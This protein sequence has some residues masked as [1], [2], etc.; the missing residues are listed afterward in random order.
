MSLFCRAD[1][2]FLDLSLQFQLSGWLLNYYYMAH[3]SRSWEPSV[4]DPQHGHS[5]ELIA[6][7]TWK[8][9]KLI[10][11]RSRCTPRMLLFIP[12]LLIAILHHSGSILEVFYIAWHLKVSKRFCTAYWVLRAQSLPNVIVTDGYCWATT[13]SLPTCVSVVVKYIFTSDIWLLWWF[14]LT[15]LE[16][17]IIYTFQASFFGIFWCF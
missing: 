6:L 14:L 16:T 2:C 12:I 15:Q 5:S 10:K 4:K 7:Y 8:N 3:K 13:I 11:K 1:S 9:L 17:G